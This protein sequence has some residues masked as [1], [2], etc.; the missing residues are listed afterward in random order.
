[1]IY[2]S[3]SCVKTMSIKEAIIQL[4]N[5]GFNNIELSSGTEYYDGLENDLREL[6]VKHNLRYLCHNYFP[7]SREH[8]VLNLASLSDNIYEKSIQHLVRSIKFSS[9]LGAEKFGFH[10]GFLIDISPEEMGNRLK[11]RNINDKIKAIERFCGAVRLLK[12]AAGDMELYIENNVYSQE[13]KNT[14]GKNSSPLMLINYE[15]YVELKKMVDFKLLLDVAHL[16]VSCA[17]LGI[18][19]SE[20]L[21]SLIKETDYFHLS[22]NDGLS[23]QNKAVVGN[24]HL[25]K[26]LAKYNL[27]DKTITIEIYDDL[28]EVA[29]SYNILMN[30]IYSSHIQTAN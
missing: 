24:S 7:P 11:Y 26:L 1:M 17:S 20:E 28:S 3:S 22:E 21:E 18:D 29:R 4:Y 23:D 5:Y 30:V 6:Q 10:A 19:F 15:D 14:Y 16:K 27:S 8:F 25:L 2:I 9:E 12:Q 13:N